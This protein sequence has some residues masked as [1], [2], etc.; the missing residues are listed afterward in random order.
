MPIKLWLSC[1]GG[2]RFGNERKVKRAEATEW[3]AEQCLHLWGHPPGHSILIPIPTTLIKRYTRQIPKMV[4]VFFVNSP[5]IF[6]LIESFQIELSKQKSY[7]VNDH[8]TQEY[9][10]LVSCIHLL[11]PQKVTSSLLL[12]MDHLL[13]LICKWI[14]TTQKLFYEELIRHCLWWVS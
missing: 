11:T 12:M 4:K 7:P 1:P 13:P 5:N 3:I 14:N 8:V 6:F 2:F 10:Y 9:I